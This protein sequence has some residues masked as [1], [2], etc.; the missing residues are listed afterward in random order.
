MHTYTQEM[1]E[2]VPE[3]LVFN[4]DEIFAEV[5]MPTKVLVP[6]NEKR[7]PYI[8]EFDQNSH[9]TAMVTIN[10][11]GDMFPPFLILP[12]MYLPKNLSPMVLRCQMNIGRPKMDT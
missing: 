8:N 1:A 11:A 10:S 2:G 9:I 7:G 5:G 4:A 6:P 3:D 12:L